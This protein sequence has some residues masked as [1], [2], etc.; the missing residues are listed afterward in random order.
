M[1]RTS[2]FGDD[3]WASIE[4]QIKVL[5]G[6]D[7]EDYADDGDYRYSAALDAAEWLA[8]EKTDDLFEIE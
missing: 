6:K 1:P 2:F 3:N 7:A 4:A 5:Q 8:G